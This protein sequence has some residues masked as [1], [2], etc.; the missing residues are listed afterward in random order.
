MA[1]YHV[2]GDEHPLGQLALS[3][4][5][6]EHRSILVDHGDVLLVAKALRSSVGIVNDG[7]VVLANIVVCLGVLV[8]VTLALE[9]GVRHILLVSAPGNALVIEQVNDG[10]NVGWDLLEVVVVAAKGITTNG[11]DVVGHR[12]VCHTEVVVN[13][14]TLRCK[15]LQVWVVKCIVI[16]GV[17]QPDGHETI[18]DLGVS[19]ALTIVQKPLSHTPCRGRGKSAG[20]SLP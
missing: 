15:P 13:A 10:G 3:K 20:W 14:D 11:G 19:L 16:V 8:D 2:G 18:E 12:R 4:I 6:V 17:L 5:L 1:T 9:T 7:G